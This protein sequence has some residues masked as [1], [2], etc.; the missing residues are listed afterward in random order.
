MVYNKLVRDKIPEIIKK[1]G[2]ECTF[3]VLDN[4]EYLTMLEKKLYEE[5]SEYSSD[6]SIY[7]L[8]DMLEVIYAVCRAQGYSTDELESIRIKKAEERGGFEDKIFLMETFDGKGDN[9]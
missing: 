7:E 3:R 1:N 9:R 6:K 8:A 2:S 5:L 4:N